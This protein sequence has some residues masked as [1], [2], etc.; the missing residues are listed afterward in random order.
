M[1]PDCPGRNQRRRNPRNHGRA[2]SRAGGHNTESGTG[3]TSGG[4]GKSTRQPRHRMRARG[5]RG[6]FHRQ[7][8]Q[9][10]SDPTQRQGHARPNTRPNR[11]HTQNAPHSGDSAHHHHTSQNAARER[12]P[13]IRDIDAHSFAAIPV[14]IDRV[15]GSCSPREQGAGICGSGSGS[16]QARRRRSRA[17]GKRASTRWRA[18]LGHAPAL[19]PER[20]GTV[21]ARSAAGSEATRGAARKRAT[22]RA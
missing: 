22:G 10:N 11:R 3:G 12:E 6:R 14:P 17:T 2:A 4:R 21:P 8:Q 9:R 13:S 15:L 5:P 20:L 19:T 7:N 16:E 18:T 1:P